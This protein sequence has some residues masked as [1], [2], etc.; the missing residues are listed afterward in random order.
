MECS[1]E[2]ETQK[3]VIEDKMQ[4]V[5]YAMEELGNLQDDVISFIGDGDEDKHLLD[6]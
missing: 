4:N 2:G 3:R 5:K 6:T 1:K